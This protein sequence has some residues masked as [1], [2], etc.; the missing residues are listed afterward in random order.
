MTIHFKQ[1]N[2]IVGSYSFLMLSVK[3]P[4]IINKYYILRFYFVFVL[5]IKKSIVC[6]ECILEKKAVILKD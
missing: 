1:V 4:Q 2:S 6:I 5:N 3:I